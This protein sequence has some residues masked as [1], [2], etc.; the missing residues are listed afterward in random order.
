M[1]NNYLW[2]ILV[3]T[4]RNDGRPF[5]LRYHKV[6]DEKVKA[7]SGGLTIM[8]PA[9]GQWID[10]KDGKEYKDRTIPVRFIA[11]RTQMQKIVA[12]SC[13]YYEQEAM[14]CYRIADEVVLMTKE[15]AKLHG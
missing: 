9:V 3:P 15:E 5:Y 10:P 2:E 13:L 8:K 11:T 7:I 6:W 4:V 1:D 12:M 14:L